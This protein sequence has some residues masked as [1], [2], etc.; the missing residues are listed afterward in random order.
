[1]AKNWREVRKEAVAG[2]LVDE[3]KVAEHRTRALAELQAYRLADVR[4]AQHLTQV[5]VAQVMEVTQSRVSQLEKGSLEA[6]EIG[7]VRKYVE[8]LGGHL[9]VM[10]DF[11]A[12]GSVPI[13]FVALNEKGV[14]VVEAK[15]GPPVGEKV[16]AAVSKVATVGEKRP[17]L[18]DKKLTAKRKAL[19]RPSH[20]AAG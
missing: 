8:A 9:R 3:A 12:A 16:P 13:D 6:S 10:A 18:V 20:R 5:E 19:G 7:T 17:A 11:G 4:K 2:G 15:S 14:V 1:M